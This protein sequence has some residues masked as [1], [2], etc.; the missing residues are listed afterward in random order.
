M[1]ASVLSLTIASPIWAQVKTGAGAGGT[2][3]TVAQMGAGSIS[4]TPWFSNQAVRTHIGINDPTFNQ[5]NNAYGQAYT[6][7]NSGVSQLGINLTPQQR[8]Q[9][10][11]DLQNAF[12]QKMSQA[13]QT[14]IIDPTQLARY[15]QLALQFQGYGAFNDPQVQQKLALT[16]QQRQQ[17]NQFAE[18]YN[19]QLNA[20][21]QKA[22]ANPQA[23]N[24]QFNQ[25][26]Q[27]SM[28]NI[29]S[30]LTPQQQQTWL[31]MTGQPYNFQW[32]NYFPPPAAGQQGGNQQPR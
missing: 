11:Q 20:L 19:Q 23:T 21:Q 22:Q 12:N 2:Q 17:L 18:Q 16:D 30:V 14:S 1:A 32:S 15:N 4:Q 8:A 10:M 31:Q 5:L 7:Y 24:Q 25:F 13:A 29:N 3:A 26:R 28:Q 6:T 27:Q 9:R